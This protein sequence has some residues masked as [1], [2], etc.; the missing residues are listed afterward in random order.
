MESLPEILQNLF[1]GLATG[2]IYAIVA[3]GF[4]IIFSSTQVVNF[5]QG[6]FV[7]LGAM[8]TYMLTAWNWRNPD[9]AGLHWPLPV[10]ILLAVALA[11][12][13]GLLLGWVLMRPLKNASVPS[14]IIITIGASMLLQGVASQLWGKDAVP[15][16]FFTNA[17]PFGDPIKFKLPPIL[18]GG[19]A[20]F[21]VFIEWQQVWVMALTLLMVL[22]LSIFFNRT[23]VGKAMRAV[24]VNRHGARLMGINVSRMV[25]M[26]FAL[27]A[28]M[29]ALAGA[30]VAPIS[31][32][33]FNMG[34]MMGL[35]GFAAAIVGG[36]GNFGGSV[37]AGLLLGVVEK[38]AIMVPGL[39]NYKD[40]VAFI[41]LLAMLVI[42][43]NGLPAL[44]RRRREAA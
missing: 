41:I 25:V 20:S 12:V 32:G 40:A 38:L 24:S 6:E 5:A 28:A 8:G 34:T 30:A 18:T 39:S 14:L 13:I 26:A 22:G 4:T 42:S 29:G 23:L 33:Y 36:L 16:A 27:S 11:A 3:V 2:S 17:P 10:A 44:L 19:T 9:F 37:A 15:A 21:P 35:K 1:S 31:C 7:M 43:P